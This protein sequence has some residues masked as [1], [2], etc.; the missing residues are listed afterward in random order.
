MAMTVGIDLGTTNSLIGFNDGERVQLVPNRRGH[1]LTPSV[2]GIDSREELIVGEAARNQ[3]VSA[4]GRT[5]RGVKRHMGERVTLPLGSG[6]ISPEEGS[7]AI[8][9]ALRTDVAEFT[10]GTTPDHA[11]VTVPAHFDDRQRNATVEAALLAGFR[12]VRLLNEPTA[13]ALPYAT[14]DI[15]R[16]R[17]VVFDFGGGTLDITCLERDGG[18]FFVA[19]TTGD[20][21]LGGVDIDH[22][23]FEH[24]SREV[25]RQTGH[26]GTGDPAIEQML[27]NLAETAKTELSDLE[28]TSMTI[29]FVAGRKGIAHLSVELTRSELEEAI[30][31]VVDRAMAMTERAIHDAGF[32][33]AGFDTLVLAGGSTRLPVIRRSLAERYRVPLAAMINPEEVVAV[34]ATQLAASRSTGRFSLHD[35]VSGTL[36]LEL[37]DGSCVPIVNRNQTIPAQRTRVFTTV[38]DGQQEAEIHLLQGDRPNACQNRSLGRFFLKGLQEGVRGEPR[39]SV[40][41]DVNADGVVTVRAGDELSGAANEMVARTRPR[42]LVQKIQGDINAWLA[43]LVRRGNRLKEHASMGLATELGDV[44]DLAAASVGSAE[45]ENTITVLETLIQEITARAMSRSASGDDHASG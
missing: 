18:E 9:S 30:Q 24:L 17:I 13:A 21:N 39:I 16:E 6:R 4:P 38:A 41:V 45:V 31:P 11:V 20:G 40:T 5:L 14:R 29:P 35:V 25:V 2:I 28:R 3:V 19:S 33:G 10:G 22:I 43:S 37:A 1:I 26:D 36:V 34:G 8:L 32:D 42:E 44:L 7:A 23:V 12:E 27:R 15:K